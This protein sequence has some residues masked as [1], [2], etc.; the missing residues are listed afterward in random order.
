MKAGNVLV[1][2]LFTLLLA[3]YVTG[4]PDSGD[5]TPDGDIDVVDGDVDDA[6]VDGDVEEG[7]EEEVSDV[8]DPN[9]CT[10]E[11][12][13]VCTDND[14]TAECS[15]DQDYTDYG[16]GTCKPTDPCDGDTTCAAENRVCTNDNGSVLCGDC[17]AGFHA[18]GDA[19][20]ADEECLENTCNG[21]GTCSVTD[22]VVSCACDTGYAG[23]HCDACDGD[24]GWHFGA[25]DVTCTQDVCDPNPCTDTNKT[26]CA[27]DNG[28]A[29]CSCDEGFTDYG[30][31][32]CMPTDPCDPNPCTDDNKTVCSNDAGTAVCGCDDGFMDYGDGACMPADPCADDTTCAAENRVCENDGGSVKCGGCMAGYHDESEA[33]VR[34][35]A[36][37]ESTCS[38]NGA[39]SVI[40]NVPTCDCDDGY[41][42][43][44]CDACDADNGYHWNAAGD[45]C[46]MDACDPN[47]CMDEHKT[48][49]TDDGGTA[50]CGCDEG[51]MD[52]GDGACMPAD[53][54]A[55]DTTCAAEN[56]ECT[57]DNG[58]VLCGDCLAGFHL[59]GE[60]CVADTECLDDT[61]SGNGTCSVVDGSPV[62]ACNDGYAGD[63]CDAC[64]TDN[65]WHWNT[66]G[67]ACTQNLCDPN[68][69]N[70]ANNEVCAEADGTCSCDAAN[71][72]HLSSDNSTCT[73][74]LCDPNPCNA[75][76]N[77][78]CAEADGSCSC[79]AANGW[80]LSSD[81]STCTQSLCDPNP[82][83]EAN[84]EV[85]AEADG[86]CSCD[87]ANGWHLSGDGSTCTQS[88][89]DPNPCNE[90]NNE[91]C[92]EA[93]GTCSCDAAN[94]WHLSGDGSTCTQDLCD[95]NPCNAANNEVCAPA[96][97]TCSC[98]A[99]NGWHLGGDGTTCTQDLCDPNP[100]D[101][102]NHEACSP[103][104][105]SCPCAE[106][107]HLSS[108]GSTC[109]QSLCDPNPC[110]EANNEVC[111]EADGTCSCD[112]VNGWH[113]SGDGVTCTQDLC[114]P[115]PCNEA[116]N[117]ICIEDDGSCVCDAANGWHLSSD[118]TTCTQDL[119][120]PNPCNEANNE[121]CAEADGSC[122]CDAANGW[123]LS[124]DG[125]TCTQDLC[126]PNPCNEA[127][128]EVCNEGDGTCSCADGWHLG[129]DG[130]TCTQ[131]LCDPN[132]CN[133]A[134]NEVCV[135][136]DGSCVCDAANGWHLS[137]DG[138]TCTQNLCDPNPCNEANMEVCNGDDGSCS[139]A[140][141][142]HLSSD[143][144]TCTQS[145]CDPNPCTEQPGRTLCSE[146]GG[147]P[148]CDCAPGF[149]DMDGD[150][151]ANGDTCE[152]AIS[153]IL[154]DRSYIG[155]TADSSDD[156]TPSCQ[157]SDS[158]DMVFTFTLNSDVDAT[159]SLANPTTTFDT[160]LYMRAGSCEDDT[161]EAC[162]DDFS[163]T[164]SLL[165][166]NLPAGDYWLFVDGY[167]GQ[168]GPFEMTWEITCPDPDEVF[169]YDTATC[170]PS[171]CLNN[172]TGP[173]DGTCTVTGWNPED[174]QCTCADGYIWDG[175]ACAFAKQT[176]VHYYSDWSPPT[177]HY[178][179]GAGEWL[180]ATMTVQGA[181]DPGYDWW[182]TA[183]IDSIGDT[184]F[185]VFTD[186]AGLWD[187]NGGNNY[188]TTAPEVWIKFGVLYED[189][190]AVPPEACVPGVCTLPNKTTCVELEPGLGTCLCNDGF[191]D[192]GGD[193][194]PNGDSCQ[195]AIELN[196]P[197]QSLMGS[198][199]GATNSYTP[200][201]QGSDSAER[202][203]T[204]TLN[205]EVDAFATL[206]N[207]STDFDT[208][209]YLY[210]G[211]SCDDFS[212]I[213][214][215]DDTSEP[216]ST[217][218]TI[219]GTLPA[220]SY[221]LFVD[222]F[223]DHTGSFEL[224][225]QFSC[226]NAGEVFDYPS[227]SCVADP[228]DGQCTGP[229]DTGC[230]ATSGSDFYCTCAPDYGWDGDSCEPVSTTIVHYF[231]DW[232]T[233][234][235][236]Y[237]DGNAPDWID[238]ELSIESGDGGPYQ[239]FMTDT[240]VTWFGPELT[241][242]FKDTDIGDNWDNNYGR[243]Y[244]TSAPEVWVYFNMI[245]EDPASI[246][247]PCADPGV[248]CPE[249]NKGVCVVTGAEFFECYCDPSYADDGEGNCVYVPQGD[250]CYDATTLDLAANS[251][252][253]D[254][255]GKTASGV[256]PSCS[257]NASGPDKVYTFTLNSA[258]TANF[259]ILD[260][261][262]TTIGD[263]VLYLTRD[264]N[265]DDCT[266]ATEV[267]CD[268]DGGA[269]LLSWITDTTLDAGTY[270]L[271]VKSY[272]ATTEGTFEMSY[273]FTC[274]TPG[275]VFNPETAAC[276]PEVVQPTACVSV[277]ASI[278]QT[279]SDRTFPVPDGLS[280]PGGS[281]LI[282]GRNADQATFEAHYGVTLAPNVFYIN[283][284]DQFPSMNGDETF[285]IFN[286][287]GIADGPTNPPV[288][289][290]ARNMQ[291]LNAALPA[292]EV[293]S[294]AVSGDNTHVTPGTSIMTTDG[295]QGLVISEINDEQGSGMYIFEYIEIYCD[296][297]SPAI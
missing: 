193:C 145:V 92:A 194:I 41:T 291:R 94:G 252:V 14:G 284:M 31:G 208:V 117:E 231:T 195:G 141:G 129:G 232:P 267:A 54:C 248:A 37:L 140:D 175:G 198:T 241:F 97:G 283:G 71:G 88:L 87:A 212:E 180:D 72:W 221:W 148:V 261:A 124:S 139:C 151:I 165:S 185:F 270:F 230:V 103:A 171:P 216:W 294:W 134:N 293:A 205:S 59:D 45:A 2:V 36:C 228:C 150:C 161:N 126:D 181:D 157:A 26:V 254:N 19:C 244:V 207:A 236:H 96:D 227:A 280:I 154:P 113:L 253:G 1:R 91:V 290:S 246:P 229:N 272:G 196:L 4:C 47:P 220:G 46:T 25:D 116:N 93:D 110:N 260:T 187:N 274:P 67:D 56:R 211:T 268:D 168:N 155:T 217:H 296:Y 13:T 183:T 172:C 62:C 173:N 215:N 166:G 27:D 137:G 89:C 184:F 120:D 289:S 28:T 106:D 204:F 242:V 239:W 43:D 159:V 8:C 17:L 275:D 156:Y 39:C 255:I 265:P 271:Y 44:F 286:D 3:L 75:A 213:A 209:M 210:A 258:V 297:P 125:T 178:D 51:F 250:Y 138:T 197:D 22:G 142:W 182:D 214:C 112:A 81:N 281:Y 84:N 128:N 222:G 279:S 162:N 78:V 100:C 179:G 262:E 256:D 259:E 160:V 76:N 109:T 170:V 77:E 282:V 224:T 35:T 65:G 251:L 238:T 218:S 247:S 164:Q 98:D 60:A 70:E 292:S 288:S 287:G 79:D 66:A 223:N 83:N 11:H 201:C 73:Q 122:S 111:A 42:G 10:D 174:W 18:D 277:G 130:V 188:S 226:P 240:A 152:G 7:G 6:D 192:V 237:S 295:T 266:T 177:I 146:A 15:C 153:L 104:D 64:D 243:N 20:V 143:G 49:C 176:I 68:P 135:E 163:S 225:W 206:A 55:D 33:C 50:V 23:D 147:F 107:W 5:V 131:S 200:S 38:G 16:D 82:C 30:D 114:D 257:N 57:N 144:V 95:P 199:V 234:W 235:M 69:C 119:C 102:D 278:M 136:D 63:H 276:E 12:K 127:N 186:G 90:A 74:S 264:D 249:P 285:T 189:S 105:G 158:V 80:H 40:D 86:T 52:Y 123:H 202:I 29:A 190:D 233:A 219:T 115:N 24:N 32:S 149:D 191:D 169:N 99:A 53:P 167:N 269:S 21:H 273:S 101:P 58:S 203:Y 9:P 118:G 263:T 132:T 48:V 34:D 85:C 61:C 121:V 108:D 133:E 245:Y